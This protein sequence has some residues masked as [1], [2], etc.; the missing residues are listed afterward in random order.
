MKKI[1]IVGDVGS[2]KSFISNLFFYPVFNADLEVEKI[3]KTNR[4]CFFK[5][6]KKFEKLNFSFPIK[7]RFITSFNEELELR[8]DF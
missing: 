7:M 5:I 6:K 8:V 1:A 3:Y 2:G 4:K